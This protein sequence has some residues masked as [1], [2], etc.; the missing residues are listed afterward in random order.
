MTE[1]TVPIDK[2]LVVVDAECGLCSGGARQ[3][4][5]RDKNDRFRIVPLQ[6]P[7]GRRLLEDHGIDPD[8][9]A[10]WLY[11][12]GDTALTGFDG[13][14][15]VGEVLGG[16]AR[17]LMLLRLLPKP[18]RARLYAIMAR[19]RM[20]FFGSDDLCRLPAPEVARRLL[21]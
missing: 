12:E 13:W 19:N 9:P 20:T 7:L 11:L 4:A 2:I 6:S 8:D 10:S 14:A 21:Q 15:R 3:L 18:L 16:S 17:V 1:I 5:R